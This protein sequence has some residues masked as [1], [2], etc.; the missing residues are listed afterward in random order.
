M[1]VPV[2]TWASRARDTV[3]SAAYLQAT[4]V[5]LSVATEE[6]RDILAEEPQFVTAVGDFLKSRHA[7][8]RR[9]SSEIIEVL[10]CN[11]PL[12]SGILMEEG[13]GS[14]LAWLAV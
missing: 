4:R 5:N 10:S 1:F 9:I 12:R 6:E 8:L 13:I 11:S 7:A 3:V 2:G 14:S